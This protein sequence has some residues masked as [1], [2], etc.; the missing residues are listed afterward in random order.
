M[1][2]K[3][4]NR[5]CGIFIGTTNFQLRHILRCFYQ[6]LDIRKKDTLFRQGHWSNVMRNGMRIDVRIAL[7]LWPK[8]EP[9]YGRCQEETTKEVQLSAL[10]MA[11]EIEWQIFTPSHNRLHLTNSISRSYGSCRRR[12]EGDNFYS[13]SFQSRLANRLLRPTLLRAALGIEYE[14]YHSEPI[15]II[16]ERGAVVAWRFR[17]WRWLVEECT[18]R[19]C[20]GRNGKCLRTRSVN[21]SIESEE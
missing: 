7:S 2:I 17:S 18:T 5:V 8:K 16:T 3:W 21:N 9:P 12:F 15:L 19:K 11:F 6:K 20:C 4:D 1:P 13:I 10:E 14:N